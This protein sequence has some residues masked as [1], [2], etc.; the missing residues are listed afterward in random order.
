VI[1]EH[2]NI[3]KQGSSGGGGRNDGDIFT[4]Q[5]IENKVKQAVDQAIIN[6]D[7]KPSPSGNMPV[8]L[9][10]GWTGVLLHEAVGHGLEADFNRK[11]TSVYSKMYNKKITSSLC[12]IVDDG[13][14][15]NKRGSL[16][17]D[18]EGN[19]TRKTVLIEKG[20]LK[21]Y[22]QD[23]LNANLMG[24][25]TTGNGRRESYAHSPMP[26]MTNTYMENGE[27]TQEEMI[28]SIKDG[29][30]AQN[31][32]GGQVDI[33]SGQFVFSMSSAYK[34]ENGK[35][36]YPI[37]GATLIGNGSDVMN[38]ISMVGNDLKLDDG[39]GVCGKNGQSVPVGVG[40]PSIKIDSIVVGGTKI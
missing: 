31:F 27:S 38:N 10:N 24:M 39:V 18:D 12:T 13:T 5:W 14:I 37:D 26:R 1:A 4:T 35:I 29:I 23:K 34:I 22:M 33:T 9:G 36:T 25:K 28:S 15:A 2:N 16:Q 19:P 7:A 40:Q 30:F 8:V 11:K 6:L 32:S 17:C 20:I 3:K 21:N